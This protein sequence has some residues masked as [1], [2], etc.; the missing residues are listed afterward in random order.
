LTAEKVVLYFH[1]GG[2]AVPMF[3]GHVVFFAQ[4][5][6]KWRSAGKKAVMTY[7]EYGLTPSKR[8]PTQYIQGTEALR[9]LLSKGYKESN[10]IVGGDSAGG[11]LALAIMSIILHPHPDIQ[12]LQLQEPLA[13]LLLISP[14]I[15]FESNTSSFATNATKDMHSPAVMHLMAADLASPHERNNYTEPARTDASWWRNL[16]AKRT[17]NVFGGYEMFR[18]DDAKLGVTLKEAGAN[19]ESV[20]CPLQVHIDCI[21][22]AQSNLE[23]GPMSTKIWEWFSEVL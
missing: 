3:D 6:E 10:I 5:A 4:C 20:E 7:L 12:P 23:V 19:V 22:D 9:L 17:L 14:W 8:Y 13:G 15:S 1:G 2:Y 18:D 21:L 11:N 16:P